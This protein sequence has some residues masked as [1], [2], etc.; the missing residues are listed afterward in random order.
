MF[1]KNSRYDLNAAEQ[2]QVEQTRREEKGWNKDFQLT[3]GEMNWGVWCI[4]AAPCF[5]RPV[6]DGSQWIVAV[7]TNPSRNVVTS[8]SN[9]ACVPRESSLTLSDRN[10]CLCRAC[11]TLDFQAQLY[12]RDEKRSLV[13][14]V[15]A[16]AFSSCSSDVPAVQQ[17]R[18]V[19]TK[20]QTL[21]TCINYWRQLCFFQLL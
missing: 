5:H 7:P 6:M 8:I 21:L 13:S 11:M 4:R 12:C 9:G 16:R 18:R 1:F 3:S 10:I 15:L 20:N 17:Q 2:E 19:N 14:Q